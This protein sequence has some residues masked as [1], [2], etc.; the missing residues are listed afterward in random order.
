M[1]RYIRGVTEQPTGI[2]NWRDLG[3]LPGAGGRPVRPGVLYRSA[4]LS[5][6][7]PHDLS[8]LAMLGVGPVFD[9]RTG[10]ERSAAPDVLPDSASAVPLDV[11]ADKNLSA[12]PTKMMDFLSSPGAVDTALRGGMAAEMMETNYREMITLPSAVAA[13]RTLLHDV[14]DDPR[15]ALVH[16]TSGKDRTGWAAAIVLFSVGADEATVRTDYLRT[17]ELYLPTLTHVFEKF[18][19][20]GGDPAR[21]R[22]LLGVRDEYLQ[23]ALDEARRVHGSI[24]AYLREALGVDDALREALR[25]KLLLPA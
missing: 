20:A 15:P 24:D 23:A 7:S 11:F 18:A 5:A 17:N 2:R 12:V 4:D 22:A 10:A 13:F 3:G 25:A 6:P 16:C 8:A 9:L 1:L 19:D 21:L 14:A